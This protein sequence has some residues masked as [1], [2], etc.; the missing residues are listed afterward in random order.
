MKALIIRFSL[1]FRLKKR[2]PNFSSCFNTPKYINRIL[3]YHFQPL[4]H[5]SD[6]ASSLLAII[7]SFTA[8]FEFFKHY[9]Y[10]RFTS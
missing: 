8:H 1:T 9:N 2:E 10:T 5:E 6:F 3:L 7:D 4:K